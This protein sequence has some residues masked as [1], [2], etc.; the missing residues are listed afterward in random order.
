MTLREYVLLGVI[1]IAVIAGL[2]VAI[3]ATA[4]RWP[5]RW[6][7]RDSWLTRPRRLETPSFFRALRAP[8]LANALPEFGT[9][10]GGESKRTIPGR[11]VGSLQRYLLEVRRAIWV[12]VF[13]MFTWLPLL[14]FNP[15]GMTLAGAVIAVV[16]NVPFLIVL[17]GNNARLSRMLRNTGEYP[18]PPQ[19]FP[20]ESGGNG[21]P[22]ADSGG[23]EADPPESG[24][25][26]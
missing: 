16:I 25:N 23:S 10:F 11:D 18:T 9:M 5:D 6:L 15:W 19:P 8:Q 14:A 20:P 22:G 24:G 2:S 13:S 17:R 21:Q 1:D 12:H 3:G 26:G 7:M 4:P